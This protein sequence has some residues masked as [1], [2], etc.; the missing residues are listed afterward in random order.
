MA[1]VRTPRD[2]PVTFIS[3][4]QR[5]GLCRTEFERRRTDV[6]HAKTEE[7]RVNLGG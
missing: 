1:A 5:G 4:E 2:E 7:T 3:A 6:R